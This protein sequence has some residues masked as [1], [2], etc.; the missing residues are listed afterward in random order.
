VQAAQSTPTTLPKRSRKK[1]RAHSPHPGVV[2]IPP[3]A[4]GGHT[5]WRARFVDPDTQKMKKVRLDPVDVTSA[6]ARRE[7]A[8]RK[9][10]ALAKR[11]TDI[12]LGAP[13]ATGTALAEATGR[14][15]KANSRLRPGT[16]ALYRMIEDRLLAW[17]TAEGIKSA[18]DLT[19]GKLAEYRNYLADA[20]R[21][22]HATGEGRKAMRT[23][24]QPRSG[25]TINSDLRKT[26]TILRYLIEIDL[27]P[28]VSELDLRRSLKKVQVTHERVEYLRSEELQKLLEAAQRHD[29]DTYKATRTEHAGE[30]EAG[31]TRR[32]DPIAPF[33]AYVMLTGCRLGEALSVEWRNVD[34]N[35]LDHGGNKVGEIHLEGKAVKTKRAR[36]IDL[37]VSPALRTLLAAMRVKSGGKGSV[38]GIAEGAAD[39][40]AKRLRKEYGAP[41]SF[42]WQALRR[43]CGTYLTNA[44]GI[45]GAASAYRSAKQLGHSVAVAEK[46]YLGLVRGIPATARTLEAAMQVEKQLAQMICSPGAETT[47]A[48][49]SAER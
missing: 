41:E 37:A 1:R 33:V 8:I 39:A 16:L 24:A 38:F 26:G 12:E 25:H 9:S 31:T 21:L 17:A 44:P 22:V 13:K 27:L 3:D 15:F 29:A 18:D 36:T 20:P 48:L 49:A 34:L 32:Y 30:R 5:S 46:H 47:L 40:A 14:F 2:L 11:R 28:K 10:K 35:A 19:R 7:W 45:F 43:T 4:S 23:A 42:T 6:E